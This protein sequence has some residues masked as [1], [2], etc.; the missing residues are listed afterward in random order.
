MASIIAT[1]CHTVRGPSAV[2]RRTQPIRAIMCAVSQPSL[3]LDFDDVMYCVDVP[4]RSPIVT[5]DM[6]VRSSAIRG[7]AASEMARIEHN[8]LEIGMEG[9]PYE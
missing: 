2:A 7:K 8:R 1:G 9:A 3:D 4:E 5:F 6:M